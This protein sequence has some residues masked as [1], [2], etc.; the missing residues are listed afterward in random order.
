[1]HTECAIVNFSKKKYCVPYLVFNPKLQ[2]SNQRWRE[3]GNTPLTKFRRVKILEK[4]R[5]RSPI[6]H[7]R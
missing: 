3:L 6:D 4:I 7:T 1:M 5:C 2:L